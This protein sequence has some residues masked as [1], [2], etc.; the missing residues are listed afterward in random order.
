MQHDAEPTAS[1]AALPAHPP[2]GGACAPP[3]PAA[4]TPLA[5]P[6]AWTTAPIVRARS[7]D[8]A[9]YAAP[10]R[11]LG[12][13]RVSTEAQDEPGASPERQKALLDDFYARSGAGELL[14]FCEVE[15]GT[16]KGEIRRVEV[17][18]LLAQVRAGDVVVVVDLDR[19][20]R[21]LRFA[22]EKVRE[23]VEKGARFIS[24]REGEFDGTPAGEFKLAVYAAVA[25]L[26]HARIQERTE[27]NRKRLRSMGKWVEGKEWREGADARDRA[28]C[29]GGCS[30]CLPVMRAR[31]Q[32]G[33]DFG[34]SA[35]ELYRIEV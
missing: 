13:V 19:F 32:P 8:A 29:G 9:S 1:A 15:S 24:L 11:V 2:V 31:V 21:D 33:Q 22:V 20:T 5:A 25:Q 7:A 14:P 17:A 30:R 28:R 6:S 23:I 16:R 35:P 3:L 12:Y 18:R 10:R 27:G 26:E 34:L 4:C